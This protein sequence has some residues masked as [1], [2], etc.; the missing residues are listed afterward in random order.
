MLYSFIK[1]NDDTEIN[2][3]EMHEDK[4]VDVVVQKPDKKKGFYKRAICKLPDY[5]W[6]NIVGF[7]DKELEHFQTLVQ[8]NSKIII[9]SSKKGGFLKDLKQTDHDA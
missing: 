1:L 7:N 3:S 8:A 9:D 4:T 2:H 6:D 5:K